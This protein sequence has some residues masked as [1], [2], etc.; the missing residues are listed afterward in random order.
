MRRASVLLLTYSIWAGACSWSGSK[1]GEE[2]GTGGAGDGSGGATGSGGSGPGTGGA[3]GNGPG[4]GG[5]SGSGGVAPDGGRDL[6]DP[7]APTC[8]MQTFTLESTPPDLLLVLDHSGSMAELPDGRMCATADCVAQ[9]KWAQVTAA[10][11]E[12]VSKT[13]TSIRW[14][15]KFFPDSNNI[16]GAAA[17]PVVPPPWR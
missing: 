17:A 13:D 1:A 11:N 14:G 2:N 6:T 10:I 5:N 3:G 16:C 7:D 15:L 9:E 4:S 8:G 12:V